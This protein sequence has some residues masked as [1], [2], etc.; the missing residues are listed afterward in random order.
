L[1]YSTYTDLIAE[2]D[3]KLIIEL[4]DD[5]GDGVADQAVIDQAIARADKRIDA[6]VGQRYQVP[7]SPVPELAPQL[8]AQ[9]A[10]YNLYGHRG[11]TPPEGV[12]TVYKDALSL[13]SKIS[14]GKATFGETTPPAADREHLDVRTSSNNR[15]FNRKSM[16]DF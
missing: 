13:L 11:I 7:L 8:S 4:S 2:H 10:V 15:I 16:R 9:I 14:D 5:N 12:T 6:L 1:P 3:E